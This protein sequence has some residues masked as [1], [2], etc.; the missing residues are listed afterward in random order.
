MGVCGVERCIWAGKQRFSSCQNRAAEQARPSVFTRGFRGSQ[1]MEAPSCCRGDKHLPGALRGSLDQG[2]LQMVTPSPPAP[3]PQPH[4]DMYQCRLLAGEPA[5]GSLSAQTLSW[6]QTPPQH[7]ATEGAGGGAASLPRSG[8]TPADISRP[9]RNYVTQD[10]L[11]NLRS[12]SWPSP[13]GSLLGL[14][15]NPEMGASAVIDPCLPAS[16]LGHPAQL[17]WRRAPSG[18]PRRWVGPPTPGQNTAMPG[19]GLPPLV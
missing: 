19:P 14:S 4:P 18:W 12:L 9:H 16:S 13:P 10:P 15:L 17:S 5:G 1:L 6:H 8:E 11:D 3:D 7:T 2:Q